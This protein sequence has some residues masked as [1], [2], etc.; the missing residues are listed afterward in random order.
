MTSRRTTTA[1]ALAVLAAATLLAGCGQQKHEQSSAPARHRTSVNPSTFPLYRPSDVFE[2]VPLD[3][4]PMV[5]ALRKTQQGSDVPPNYRGAEVVASTNASLG[6]L[7]TW[8]HK[9]EAAPPQGLRYSGSDSSASS[10]PEAMRSAGAVAASFDTKNGERVVL[11]FAVDPRLL[12][13]KLGSALD[14]IDKY[15]AVPGMM[16]GPLDSEMKKQIGYSIS[17][18]LDPASPIGVAFGA[19]KTLEPRN[20]RVLIV[21]DQHKAVE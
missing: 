6:E 15:Q 16:R 2:V 12:R 10:D 5:T 18:M 13:S 11:V 8:L 1:A 3:L 20:K 9:L 19:L 7:Q 21:V 17:E 4:G 14:L